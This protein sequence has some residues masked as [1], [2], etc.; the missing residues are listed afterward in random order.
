MKKLLFIFVFLCFS[1]NTILA[2]T[3]VRAIPK[4]PGET[5]PGL[6]GFW[7]VLCID[8]GRNKIKQPKQI[9][10]SGILFSK[11]NE[12]KTGVGRVYF[13]VG[14]TS[15]RGLWF[16]HH[17]NGDIEMPTGIT[18]TYDVL[19]PEYNHEIRKLIPKLID[20]F[21][22]RFIQNDKMIMKNDSIEVRLK[23]VE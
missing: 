9:A 13:N 12:H 7:R 6:Y 2:Q 4:E 16:K 3:E 18:E 23:R 15:V 17:G 19:C 22:V 8:D 20:R 1:F 21:H 11:L 10:Q 14:C 5:I